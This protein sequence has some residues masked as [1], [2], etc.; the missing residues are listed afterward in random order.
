MRRYLSIILIA[1][2]FAALLP[3]CGAK[4]EANAAPEVD[5][6]GFETE[7]AVS[8]G[9][10]LY[11]ANLSSLVFSK[12]GGDTVLTLDFTSD[13]RLSSGGNEREVLNPPKYRIY[14]L[15]EPNRLVIEFESLSYWDYTRELEAS[16]PSEIQGVF[17]HSP[18]QGG[19]FSLF[20]E[21]SD[22]CAYKAEADKSTLKITL[23][24][25]LSAE[26]PPPE[27]TD[28]GAIDVLAGE[29]AAANAAYYVVANAYRDY[30]DGALSCPEMAP[31]LAS[32]R[33][34]ILLISEGFRNKGEADELMSAILAREARAVP[35]DWSVV[36]LPFG[37]LPVY[38][39]EMEYMAAF[40]VMAARLNDVE[41]A[42]EIAVP[43]GLCLAVTP[44]RDG[45]LYAKHVSEYEAGGGGYDYELLCVADGSGRS[46]EL[47]S[48]EFD[49]IESA[50]YSPDGRKLAV[51]E[52]SGESSH[53]YI[54]DVDS[55][56]LLTDL[57]SVGFGD[58]ISA[59]CWDAMGGRIYS[60]GGSG[61]IVIH[62]Y[63]FNVP[64]ENKRH[65]IVDKK[66]ADESSLGFYD[67]EVY[68][69]ESTLEEG[70][71]MFRVKPEGGLRKKFISAGTFEFSPNGRYLAFAD[72]NSDVTGESTEPPE[73]SIM[74]LE[75]GETRN[76]MEDFS[77]YTFK[78]SLDATKLY[79]FENRLTGSAGE[80]EG[81]ESAESSDDPYPYRLWVYDVASGTSKPVAD[82][83]STN[84]CVSPSASMV[85][86][87]FVDRETLGDVVRATYILN[88]A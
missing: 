5:Y 64:A 29:A 9:G 76:I 40:D 72:D 28:S 56:D 69:C 10:A 1:A 82:L 53:L 17:N 88:I 66:G 24:P 44:E 39:E 4:E 59:Y 35:A 26:T 20:I 49:T 18:Q 11:E 84:I 74:D 21:M 36:E 15:P 6:S 60:I 81:G 57:S 16:L 78:W 52:R 61:E 41:T 68:F 32:D 47:V 86:L 42:L 54:F 45:M 13:S 8:G 22:E 71:L 51:L 30:C 73:F 23:R 79:F 75:T 87:C 50:S 46:R 25:V 77:V 63:D 62:Q 85:Y 55:R 12:E 7:E 3:G 58:T 33:A 48:F 27:E 34:N 14:S 2:L 37:S 19:A 80:G 67:G 31:V 70:A 43:D 38:S 83:T 65:T